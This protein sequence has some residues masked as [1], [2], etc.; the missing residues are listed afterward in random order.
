M[1]QR[2][3]SRGVTCNATSR[4]FARQ[5]RFAQNPGIVRQCVFPFV[6]Y[7]AKNVETAFCLFLHVLTHSASAYGGATPSFP[8]AEKSDELVRSKTVKLCP[9]LSEGGKTTF[10]NPET[11]LLK[12]FKNIEN[13]EK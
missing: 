12:K 6:L 4:F 13:V 10:H 7:S 2:T 11:W 5:C 3:P 8:I 1:L 9:R